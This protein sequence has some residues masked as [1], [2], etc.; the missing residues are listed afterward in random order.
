MRALDL[1]KKEKEDDLD[2]SSSPHFCLR[3]PTN[4]YWAIYLLLAHGATARTIGHGP[5]PHGLGPA[6]PGGAGDGGGSEVGV[7]LLPDPFFSSLPSLLP[8]PQ[9]RITY[10]EPATDAPAVPV[11]SSSAPE[12]LKGDEASADSGLSLIHI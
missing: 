5:G 11:Q 12:G 10:F 4:M 9:P 6:S 8:R 7:L 3:A 2:H 1:R